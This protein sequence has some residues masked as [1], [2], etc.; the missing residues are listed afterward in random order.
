[1]KRKSIKIFW[2]DKPHQAKREL[3]QFS[4][5][6]STIRVTNYIKPRQN[7]SNSTCVS[8]P[9]GNNIPARTLL[10]ERQWS[11]RTRLSESNIAME[12]VAPSDTHV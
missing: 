12:Q 3:K 1:M 8:Q 2:G 10:Y 5:C 6:V 7:S 9:S 11:G 4:F